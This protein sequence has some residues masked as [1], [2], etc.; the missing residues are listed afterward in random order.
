MM[1]IQKFKKRCKISSFRLSVK[2]KP[3]G[4]LREKSSFSPLR[5][6]KSIFR[7]QTLTACAPLRWQKKHLF[8]IFFVLLFVLVKN[9][10][11]A[12]ARFS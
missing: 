6:E 9:F 2:V 1:V 4:L 7:S 10:N 12:V 8:F 5:Y 3:Y 11:T